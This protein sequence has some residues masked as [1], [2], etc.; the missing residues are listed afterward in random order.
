MIKAV[1]TL[2]ILASL[3]APCEAGRF[4]T[5]IANAAAS[6][7]PNGPAPQPVGS[8]CDNCDGVGKVGDGVI[9]K[10]CPV[11]N[12]T[13]KKVV[14]SA[15]GRW[16]WDDV[17]GEWVRNPKVATSTNAQLGGHYEDRIICNGGKCS[18]TRVFVSDK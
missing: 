18:T 3:V 14:L 2:L 15:L 11:C 6:T 16:R 8:K 17:T 9:M 1:A 12:G 13:G 10:T 4:S 5:V 7:R